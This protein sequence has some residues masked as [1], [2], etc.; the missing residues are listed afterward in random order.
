MRLSVKANGNLAL[1]KRNLNNYEACGYGPECSSRST[2]NRCEYDKQ[3][4][5]GDMNW[6]QKAQSHTVCEAVVSHW[7]MNKP[8]KDQM[9]EIEGIFYRFV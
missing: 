2:C 5:N 1:Y 9:N 4:E 6:C 3:D 7:G 8:T